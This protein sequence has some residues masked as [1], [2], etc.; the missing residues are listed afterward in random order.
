MTIRLSVLP[1]LCIALSDLWTVRVP[2]AL[3]PS[4]GC[5]MVGIQVGSDHAGQAGRAS[6]SDTGLVKKQITVDDFEEVLRTYWIQKPPRPSEPSPLLVAIHGQTQDGAAFGAS[7]NFSALGQDENLMTAFPQGVDDFG[8]N[9]QGTGWNAGSAGDNSTCIPI[10]DRDLYAC[11]KSCHSLKKCGRCN[12]STCYDDVLFVKMVIERIAHDFC[13]DL[14]RVYAHGES[15][16]AM[17]VQ[18][19]VR[20]LPATFAGVST[21]FGTPLVGY[22]LG[23]R[24]QLVAEQLPLSRTA[25]LALHGRNDTTIPPQGGVTESGWIYEPLA[26]ST[27]V[28]AAVHHCNDRVTHVATRWDGGPKN[29]QCSEF[30]RCSTGRRI[31]QCMYDGVHGDWP[32]GFDGDQ[33]TLWFLFQSTRSS[34]L[35]PSCHEDTCA[36]KSSKNA[37]TTGVVP[38]EIAREAADKEVETKV[39]QETISDHVREQAAEINEKQKAMSDYINRKP[40]QAPLLP[41]VP[42]PTGAPVKISPAEIAA[43]FP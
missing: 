25:I 6:R 26:Q 3:R 9:D 24:L 20:E 34:P 30:R 18:H 38:A 17:L 7:H 10:M 28:W 19:L 4:D 2:T 36:A 40:T 13:I 16:G 42:E 31:M 15:N 14:D 43:S 39:K 8:N 23:S 5:S 27:G 29:F 21:W 22:L 32:S 35:A 11:Y 33:I 1:L 41:T 12:W 37:V